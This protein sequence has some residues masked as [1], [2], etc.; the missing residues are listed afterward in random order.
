MTFFKKENFFT[1][2]TKAHIMYGFEKI[3]K[4]HIVYV[5]LNHQHIN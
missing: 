2:Q 4:A 1:I 3:T 5:V